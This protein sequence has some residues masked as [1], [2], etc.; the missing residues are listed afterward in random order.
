[1]LRACAGVGMTAGIAVDRRCLLQWLGA[2]LVGS[3]VSHR[4]GKGSG[5]PARAARSLAARPA[6]PSLRAAAA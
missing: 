3:S 6:P 4:F 5:S 1:M 2:I